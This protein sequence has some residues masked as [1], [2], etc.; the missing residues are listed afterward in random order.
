VAT[1][2]IELND[3]E[4]RVARPGEVLTVEPGCVLFDGAKLA[5]GHDA[6]R[7]ARLLP[8]QIHDRFWAELSSEPLPRPHPQAHSVA[9]L[10]FAQLASLW[11]RFGANVDAVVFVVPATFRR[12]QLG[13]LLGIAEACGIP[14]R[15]L[16]DAAVAS[17]SEPQPGCELAHLDAGLHATVLTRLEQAEGVAAGASEITGSVGLAALRER[18]LERIAAAFLEQARFDPLH[19]AEA[20]QALF[21]LLPACLATLRT[22]DTARLEIE[23]RGRTH[24]AE[25]SRADLSG[26]ARELYAAVVDTLRRGLVADAPLALQV[27]QRLAALPGLLEALGTLPALRPIVVPAEAAC[28]GAL[29]RLDTLPAPKGGVS[30]ARRL[31]WQADAAPRTAPATLLP[32]PTHVVYAGI[33][34]R[35]TTAGLEIGLDAAGLRLPAKSGARPHHCTLALRDGGLYLDGLGGGEAWVNDAPAGSDR[36]RAGDRIRVGTPGAELIVVALAE[37]DGA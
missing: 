11:S 15:A 12:E 27:S 10:A 20:E 13:L 8:G 28:L 35:V 1:L 19:D 37:D 2:A 4:L 32:I 36:L 17:S 30:L 14:T 24:A 26:A 7:S 31:G 33:A 16:V 22:R 21:D 6:H 25:L 34:R 23:I 9:D 18:W 3:A 29:A 5:I